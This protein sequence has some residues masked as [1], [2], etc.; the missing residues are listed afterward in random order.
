MEINFCILEMWMRP[1][2]SS[3]YT[4]SWGGWGGDGQ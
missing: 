1:S 4:T 2:K 3:G